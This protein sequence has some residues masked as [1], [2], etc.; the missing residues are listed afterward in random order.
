MKNLFIN[1]SGDEGNWISCYFM[2][3]KKRVGVYFKFRENPLGMYQKEQL[4]EY[5][6]DIK[7]EL[8]EDVIWN[9]DNSKSE[10]FEV[11]LNIENVYSAENKIE[12]IEF[13]NKWTN[14][15]VNVMRPKLK[16]IQ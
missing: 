8:G 7:T 13:F 4:H 5:K 9:W 14:I 16:S 2:A 10:G 11:R 12:I 3:S 15:F 1:P 6:D